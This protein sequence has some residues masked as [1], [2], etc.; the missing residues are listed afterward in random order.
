MG[1]AGRDLTDAGVETAACDGTFGPAWDAEGLSGSSDRV[2]CCRYAG[3]TI[4]FSRLQN[5]MYHFFKA[6]NIIPKQRIGVLLE[7]CHVLLEVHFAAAAL[8][9]IV[10]VGH[11]HGSKR[12]LIPIVAES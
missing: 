8:R 11:N 9:A 4:S 12:P 2:S 7:N 5:R 3:L 10:V 6:Q 1:T